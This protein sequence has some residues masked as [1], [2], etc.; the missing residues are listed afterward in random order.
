M[1]RIRASTVLTTLVAMLAMLVGTVTL[2]ATAASAAPKKHYPPPPPSLVVN[3]GVVKKGVTVKASGR[4]FAKR[5]KVV[6]W[7]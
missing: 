1:S 7:S 4:T 6:G 2:S 3:K 5:E